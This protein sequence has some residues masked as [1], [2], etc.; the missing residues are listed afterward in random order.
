MLNSSLNWK[1]WRFSLLLW[2]FLFFAVTARA[3]NEI[4]GEVQFIGAGKVEKTS[5]VWVDGQYVGYLNE[6]KGTK[7]VLLLPGQHEISVR[8]SGYQDSNQTVVVEPGQTKVVRVTMQRDTRS[9]FPSLTAEIKLDV[10]PNRAAV[11]VDDA[12]VGHVHEFGGLGRRMLLSPGKHRVKIAL[13]GYRT[14]ETEVNLAP[15]QKFE[16]K[17]DLVKG[18]ITDAG[19]LIKDQERS[20]E[21]K[22]AEDKRDQR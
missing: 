7:K 8:Q 5:G 12:F 13:P 15:N 20:E 19:P 6:L 9:P 21:K 10:N 4:M 3:Q 16:I 2:L 14:F 17:T 22:S 1:M 18:S 11:F